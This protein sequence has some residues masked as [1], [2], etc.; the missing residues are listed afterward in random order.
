MRWMGYYKNGVFCD[1]LFADAKNFDFTLA[2]D[3][4]AFEKIGF[5]P[6]DYSAAGRL[7]K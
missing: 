2:P 6:W 7:T 3:S 5:E 4:P 1:P